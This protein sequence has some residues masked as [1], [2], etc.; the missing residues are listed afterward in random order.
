MSAY[1]VN[2][3]TISAIVKGFEV[4]NVEYRAEDYKEP[5]QILINL[6]KIRNSIGQSLLNQNYKSV[7]YRYNENS[8]TPEFKYKDVSINEGAILGCIDCYVYQACETSD[9]FESELYN[10]LMKLK[11]AMLIKLI[12]EKGQ[13]IPWGYEF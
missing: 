7:N 13:N 10:S 5:V 2:N 8:K 6:Q 4:F 1:V 3:E 12:E 11:N 9:F